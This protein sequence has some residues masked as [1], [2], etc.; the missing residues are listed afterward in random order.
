MPA[1]VLTLIVG[2]SAQSAPRP[3]R[4]RLGE[5]LAARIRRPA[6]PAARSGGKPPTRAPRLGAS[7]ATLT[8]NQGAIVIKLDAAKAPCTVN[9]FVYLAD[10]KYFDSTPCH[11]LTTA[12]I[13]VL[14]CGDP[15]GTGS[16]G[17]GYQFA[18]ENLSGAVY[19]AGTVA[20]ANGGPGT[21][22]SQ[23]FLVYADTTLAPNY[24]PFGTITGGLAVISKIAAAGSD[25]SNGQGDGKPNVPVQITNVTVATS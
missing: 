22:G 19:P 18:D 17:P 20:M 9:S 1:L 3:R 4:P 7:V 2:A 10:K 8:T 6:S 5:R 24:T 23:F 15:T 13:F 21:N 25:N 14:Q 11:R 16:G 12:G